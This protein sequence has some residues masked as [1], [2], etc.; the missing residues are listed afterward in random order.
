VEINN[1]LEARYIRYEN[2]IVDEQGKVQGE[3]KHIHD[4]PNNFL[5]SL[6]M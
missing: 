6:Y 2:G 4:A 3:M 1:E 5:R